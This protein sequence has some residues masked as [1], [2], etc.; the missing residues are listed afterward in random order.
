MSL[1]RA[2]IAEKKADST[3]VHYSP[4][5]FSA[6]ATN[7]NK[8]AHN[9]V[10]HI[11]I[12]NTLKLAK[13]YPDSLLNEIEIIVP[14]GYRVRGTVLKILAAAGE[15]E[16]NIGLVALLRPCFRNDSDFI[17]QLSEQF[18][19]GWEVE[20]EQRMAPLVLAIKTSFVELAKTKL[21]ESN[22]FDELSQMSF[23]TNL[24]SAFTPNPEQ[25]VTLGYIYS[26]QVF[27]D[28]FKIW[29]DS[30]SALGG[31]ESHHSKAAFLIY[32][33]LQAH[34]QR[35]DLEVY[36]AGVSRVLTHQYLPKRL[37][38]VMGEPLP[39]NLSKLGS[40]CWLDNDKKKPYQSIQ[41]RIEHGIW[42][43][44]TYVK[45]KQEI[46]QTILRERIVVTPGIS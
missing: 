30:A 28:F 15:F 27:S 12:D 33:V 43:A 16:K 31:L 44:E 10:Y 46:I 11:D 4:V 18:R 35:M 34:L 38:F 21:V 7:T 37:K 32:G 14:H 23:I 36:R 22:S 42:L 41:H 26:P 45:Q 24:K 39:K 20:T 40:T 3:S 5:F 29:N 13:E 6:N 19:E 25:V 17:Q 8:I 9:L 2:P 1:E